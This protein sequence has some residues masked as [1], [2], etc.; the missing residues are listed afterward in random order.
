MHGQGQS[1]INGLMRWL[2]DEAAAKTKYIDPK[3]WTLVYQEIATPWQSNGVDCG[4]FAIMV[5]DYISDDLPLTFNMAN[6]PHFRQKIGTDILRK[7][8]TY[9]HST[10]AI[11]ITDD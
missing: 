6:I 10:V 3:E 9:P 2:I 11:D 4:V 1:W 8:L 5:A 7:K